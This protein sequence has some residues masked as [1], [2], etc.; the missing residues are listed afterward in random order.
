MNFLSALGFILSKTVYNTC[1]TIS[2]CSE[3]KCDII[4]QVERM[5]GWIHELN[6]NTQLMRRLHSDPTY[7][8][9][10]QLQDQLDSAITQSN[11]LG[12]KICGAL[13]QFETRA[14]RSSRNDAASRI[15]RLQY[16]ATRALYAD[17]LQAHHRVLDAVREHQ[18]HLLQEQIRLTNL[19]ISD[20]E[21]QSLLDTKNISLFVDNVKAETAEARRALR[22]VEARHEELTRVEAS[23]REVRDLFQQLAHLVAQQQE[24]V[25][26]VEYYALQATEHVEYGGHQLLKGTVSRTKARKKKVSLIICLAAGFL[27]VLL[28][29]VLT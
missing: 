5:R 18:L 11:A 15:A 2:S 17:A 26:S 29:L 10:K 21:C 13:R 24:Q 27:I 22:A 7:H 8:N 1:T 14:A 23:L 25:D 19:T 9:N 20:E 6:G 3:S 28:V 12:L 16:A 4:V